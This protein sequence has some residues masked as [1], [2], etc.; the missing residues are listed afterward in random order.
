[1]EGACPARMDNP[2]SYISPEN[3]DKLTVIKGPETVIWGPG[4]SAG[5]ILFDRD[6]PRFSQAGVR[7][8]AS[9][10]VGSN[11]RND[12][13]TD[14]TVG[15]DKFYVRFIGNHAHAQDYKDGSGNTVPSKWDKWNTDLA[16]GFTPDADTLFEISAGTGD[17]YAR[18][19]GRSMDGTHF[20]R[21]SFSAR[22]SKDH[23]SSTLKKVEALVYEN[24]ADHVMDNFSLRVPDPSSSMPSPIAANLDR[25]T[26]GA[27]VATTWTLGPAWEV[28]AGLDW[29]QNRHRSRDG[30]DDAPYWKSAWVKDATF[31][32]TGVFAQATWHLT[33]RDR[34]IGGSRLDWVDTKDFRET[35]DSMSSSM[36]S[37]SDM[38][39][40][41]SMSMSDTSA[42]PTA[43]ER[44]TAQLPSG[45]L[46][47]ERDLR[48]VPATVYAGLGHVERFPDYWE[49]FSPDYGPQGSLNAFD[50]I[51][52]EKTTQLDIGAQYRDPKLNAWVSAYV[53]Y[54]QDFILFTYASGGSMGSTSTATNVDASIMGGEM[55]ASYA[56]TPE[57]KLGSS[58]A[59]AYGRNRTDGQPLPQIPPLE[60][61][62]TV[63]YEHGSWSAGALWRLVAPQHRVALSEGNVVGQDFGPSAGFGVFSLNTGYAF[64]QKVKLT[65]GVDNLFNKTY[66]EHL[67]LAGN[68]GFG[69][70]S[71]TPVNE[72]G[73][74]AWARLSI[75]Y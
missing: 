9:T 35:V 42:N 53:G 33:A 72:P 39:G 54:V 67:N 1:M 15:T 62:L 16:I 63:D 11:G 68:S 31:H 5:T 14:L 30:T 65:L 38:S 20:R 57:W 66:A 74:T 50:A 75:R 47:Y 23:I 10:V 28:I 49:L 12:Q 43:G 44:R 18:Y 34:L 69:F 17:G 52:P 26:V 36:D 55:G 24:Y 61:R 29:Q 4:A 2:A 13:N 58:L 37:S 27:R 70:A 3:F 22:F 40:M 41:S 73:R 60:A 8:D 25:K 56:L 21:E 51:K 46:R 7:L 71:N 19:A 6:T 32:D 45:F 59:Y 48:N 64:N